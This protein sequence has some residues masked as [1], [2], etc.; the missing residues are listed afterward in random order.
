[1]NTMKP[2]LY[3]FDIFKIE[4]GQNGDQQTWDHSWG[5]L[6][7]SSKSKYSSDNVKSDSYG[8]ADSGLSILT[9]ERHNS[10]RPNKLPLGWEERIA[11]STKECYFYDTITRKVYFRLP[12]SPYREKNRNA[13]GAVLGD[14]PEFND[15]CTLR[16]RHILVKHNES[17]RCSSHRERV[18]RRTRQEALN[19]IMHA[20]DLIQSGKCE[21]AELAKMISDCCS[22]RHGG[23]LGP[24]SLTQTSFVFERNILLLNDG[25]L[26]EIFQTN[27][28]YHILLRTPINFDNYRTQMS[29]SL[30]KIVIANE[31]AKSKA[32][33]KKSKYF[34]N[35]TKKQKAVLCKKRQTADFESMSSC[36]DSV[37]FKT[38]RSSTCVSEPP[39]EQLNIR[40]RIVHSQLDGTTRLDQYVKLIES[41]DI[42][43][44]VIKLQNV[45][46]KKGKGKN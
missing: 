16:C 12:P 32:H 33:L 43:K 11:H 45:H 24:L 41:K 37:F 3:K 28:G 38:S 5:W 27:A 6:D 39:E 20:R 10:E 31:K 44:N 42:G 26:S 18:V 46:I 4:D 30:T 40:N 7:A 13:W 9:G 8:D 29:R 15:K 36:P 35:L 21:F 2:A 1:M 14:Y 23:D 34:Y 25:E 19:M 17:D 22:A